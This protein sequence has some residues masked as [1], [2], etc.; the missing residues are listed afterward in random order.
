MCAAVNHLHDMGIIHND[1]KPQ[2]FTLKSEN[3]VFVVKLID[4][5]AA[6]FMDR[7]IKRHVVSKGYTSF[8]QRSKYKQDIRNDVY[9]LVA[10]IYEVMLGVV[11]FKTQ[12]DYERNVLPEPVDPVN[13]GGGF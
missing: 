8:E 7:D 2:N 1:L 3:G 5:G 13:G 11:L 9:S 6:C 10:T 4:F 12:Q